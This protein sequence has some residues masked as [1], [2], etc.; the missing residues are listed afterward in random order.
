MFYPLCLYVCSI[1]DCF[2][3][4][5]GLHVMGALAH[6]LTPL[7]VLGEDMPQRTTVSD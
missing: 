5:S 7:V 3:K 1:N 6:L 4:G 2:L